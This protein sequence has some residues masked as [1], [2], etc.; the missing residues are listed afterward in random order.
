MIGMKM[1]LLVGLTTAL[2]FNAYSAELMKKADFKKV[3]AQYTKI[4]TVATSGKLAPSD[5][6]KELSKK[7]D[8]KG[9]DVF[10]LTSGQTDKKIHAT[11]DVY[12]KK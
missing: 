4:G 1:S 5:A 10:V 6:V 8:E 11:A 9:G 3:E 7:A 12:K 2:A